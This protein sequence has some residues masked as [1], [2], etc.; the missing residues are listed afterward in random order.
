MRL[1]DT[2][3]HLSDVAVQAKSETSVGP[4]GVPE[5]WVEFRPADQT[6]AGEGGKSGAQAMLRIRSVVGVAFP[7]KG[8]FALGIEESKQKRI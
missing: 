1:A 5:R 7:P 4:A 2:A 3:S 6:P 8:S